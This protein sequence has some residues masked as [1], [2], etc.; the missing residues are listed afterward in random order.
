MIDFDMIGGGTGPLMLDGEGRIGKLALDVAQELGIS[1]RSF[2]LGSGAS[3]D[4]A[5]F[6]N[7]G[8]DAVFFM[9]EYTLLHT[10]Q[11]TL[12][13]VRAEWLDE[14]GRVAVRVVEKMGE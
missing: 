10:P 6:R 1:A 8:I 3:S 2:R 5:S 12:E 4:H 9:R 14:A 7:A 13:Q 11:D